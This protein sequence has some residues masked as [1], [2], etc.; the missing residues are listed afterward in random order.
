MQYDKASAFD[1][2][3]LEGTTKNSES[4]GF[5]MES[6]LQKSGEVSR[7]SN[8]V[9][10]DPVSDMLLSYYRALNLDKNDT[11]R[12]AILASPIVIIGVFY[13]L[14]S[15]SPSSVISFSAFV[16]SV[17][18]MAISM[19]MLCDILVKDVGPRGM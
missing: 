9:Y 17:L 13:L 15:Q 3:D 5:E 8:E 2:D 1:E 10:N 12:V 7:L 4:S 19:W 16:F 11:L 14:I 18:F 6:A